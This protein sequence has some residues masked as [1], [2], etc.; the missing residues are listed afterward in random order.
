MKKVLGLL[1]LCLLFAEPTFAQS[2]AVTADGTAVVAVTPVVEAT[3]ATTAAVEDAAWWSGLA[4]QFLIGLSTLVAGAVAFAVKWLGDFIRSKNK[5]AGMAYDKLAGDKLSEGA[6]RF[7]LAEIEKLRQR[8]PGHGEIDASTRER[9]VE[10]AAPKLQEEYK[11]TLKHFDKGSAGVLDF[12]R[13][14]VAEAVTQSEANLPY[15][16][17]K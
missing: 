1:L 15:P 5:L 6:I 10:A 3:P 13:A 4:D 2:A 12:L 16:M 14:R 9:L 17:K 11:T 8:I 7:L